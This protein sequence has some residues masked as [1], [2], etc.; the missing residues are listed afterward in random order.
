MPKA[1]SKRE[2]IERYLKGRFD[3]RY[4]A[5]LA[6]IEYKD[7]K[8]GVKVCIDD[9]EV[10]SII[11]WLDSEHREEFT[12]AKLLQTLKSSFTAKYHP[13]KEYFVEL[14]KKEPSTAGTWAIDQLAAT[15]TVHNS[16]TWKLSLTRWLVACVAQAFVVEIKQRNPKALDCQNQ[17]CIVL[18]GAQGAFKSTWINNLCPPAIVDYL[19]SG[20]LNLNPE[21]R[22]TLIYLA[23]KF[24]INLDDQL[25]SMIKKDNERMKNLITQPKVSVRRPHAL[26][27][28]DMQRLANFI[29]SINGSDFLADDENRRYLPFEVQAID[30]EATKEIDINMVWLQAYQLWK[31]DYRHYWT[32][33]ELKE[34]FGNMAEF[35]NNSVELEL[36]ITYYDIPQNPEFANRFLKVSD[37]L[38]FLQNFTRDRLSKGE[39]SKALKIVNAQIVTRR[40]DG[41]PLKVYALRERTTIEIEDERSKF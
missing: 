11:R 34:H 12:P 6:K 36:L 25:R 40:K 39:L 24:I 37:I 7:K 33:D 22:D 32:R 16:E 26:F 13:I 41:M 19:Y 8:T 10:N 18:T 21:A 30:I 29:G 17:N 2:R 4:N 3:F 28:D 20:T 31:A 14:E 9:Y 23:E 15:V 1:E 27:S 5:I 38:S 35:R